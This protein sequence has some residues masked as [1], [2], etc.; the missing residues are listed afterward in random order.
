MHRNSKS[1]IR[2]NK[3]VRYN[4]ITNSKTTHGSLFV[5]NDEIVKVNSRYYTTYVGSKNI[6]EY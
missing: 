5:V 4:D 1:G 2:S 6:N 3:S